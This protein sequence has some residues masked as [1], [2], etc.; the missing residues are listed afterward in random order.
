ME[1]ILLAIDAQQ[2]NMNA[3]DFACYLARLTS[4]FS[5]KLKEEMKKIKAKIL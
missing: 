3:V 5:S 2:M 1:K 4:I